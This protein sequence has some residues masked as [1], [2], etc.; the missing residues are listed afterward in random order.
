MNVRGVQ[1]RVSIIMRERNENMK[2]NPE[3]A[4]PWNPRDLALRSKVEGDRGI[5]SCD[6]AIELAPK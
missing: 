1:R 5:D 6:N 4:L 3:I 2:H